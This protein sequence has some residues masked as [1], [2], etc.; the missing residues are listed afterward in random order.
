MDRRSILEV[1]VIEGRHDSPKK[2]HRGLGPHHDNDECNGD[3]TTPHKPKKPKAKKP[4]KPKHNKPA[5][6]KQ[7]HKKPKKHHKGDGHHHHD[8]ECDGDPTTP[9]KPHHQ[10]LQKHPKP[11]KHHTGHGHHHDDDEPGKPW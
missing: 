4:Q 1:K 9:H 11:T 10:K 7:I 6:P 5:H 2:T 8:D 3:P